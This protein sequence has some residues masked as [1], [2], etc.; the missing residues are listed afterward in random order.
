[1]EKVL[2]EGGWKKRLVRHVG[3]AKDDL[4][5]AVLLNEAQKTLS[6]L[7]RPNQLTLPFPAGGGVSGLRTVGEYH[8]GAELVL[9]HL[10]D[11]LGISEEGLSGGLCRQLVIARMLYPV[12]KRRTAQFLNRHFNASLD[13]DQIYRFMDQLSKRQESILATVRDY[14]LKQY[15]GSIGYLFYDVTTLYF[16]T[17]REDQDA[18]DLPGLR[19]RGYSKDHRDD[20]PQV[21]LGLAVNAMGMPLGYRLYSGNT[22][23]GNTLMDGIDEIL[24]MLPNSNLGVVADAGMLSAKNLAALEERHL[25]YIVGARLKSLPWP[26][27]DEVTSLDFSKGPIRELSLGSRRLVVSYSRSRA[28]KARSGRERSVARLE[29]LIAKN[30][31][32]RK[33]PYL[34]FTVKEKPKLNLQAI[35]ASARWDGIKGYLTNSP[36]LP[37]AQVIDRYTDLYKVEQSF[38]MSK[39]DL[40]IRPAFHFKRERIEA[41]VVICMLALCVMRMLEEAVAPFGMTVGAAIDELNSAKSAIVQLGERQFLIPPAYSASLTR[42]IQ[43]LGLVT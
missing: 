41:H 39:T 30:Q 40:R 5:L 28:E 7:R 24:A 29:R 6:E 43:S 26:I 11:R 8:Y 32:V 31:A 18:Q 37:A 36:D 4:D 12:S 23:E 15:P 3:T 33:H 35:E 21:V 14:L 13:E 20:L 9:G 42:L 10:F 34:D 2:V 16:E 38:R 25:T 27:Q 1:M 22:Y 19:K 17:D